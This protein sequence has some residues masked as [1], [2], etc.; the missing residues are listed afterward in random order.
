MNMSKK[1]RKENGNNINTGPFQLELDLLKFIYV[2]YNKTHVTITMNS[3]PIET[4]PS[5]IQIRLKI[6]GY[7]I[8][9]FFIKKIVL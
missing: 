4:G 1:K 2:L 7:F 5:T 6:L 3:I 9:I 8:V